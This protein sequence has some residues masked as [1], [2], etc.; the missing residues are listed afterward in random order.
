M[1]RS[2]L[3]SGGNKKTWCGQH[4]ALRTKT[5]NAG[6][7]VSCLTEIIPRTALSCQAPRSKANRAPSKP[8]YQIICLM[9]QAKRRMLRDVARYAEHY[10]IWLS[11]YA[12]KNRI[13]WGGAR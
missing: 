12:L 13:P 1:N 9:M 10:L 3:P 2:K 6:R 11:L 5:K 7:G 4:Q 8:P